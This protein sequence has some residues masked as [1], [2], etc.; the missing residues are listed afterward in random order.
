MSRLDAQLVDQHPARVRVSG[1]RLG[2]PP[3]AGQRQHQLCVEP[4]TERMF[5][6]ERPQFGDELIVAAES[7]VGLDAPLK[8]LDPHLVKPRYPRVPQRLAGHV[9]QWRALPQ[10][11]SRGRGSGGVDPRLI[12]DRR[13]RALAKALEFQHV[14]LSIGHPQQV[15]G[16]A[17]H[18]AIRAIGFEDSAEPQHVTAERRCGAGRRRAIPDRV[19]QLVDRD[20]R[21]GL[22][23]QGRQQHSKAG[24]ADA[25]ALAGVT[26]QSQRPQQDESHSATLSNTDNSKSNTGDRYLSDFGCGLGLKALA[27]NATQIKE[28]A[29]R[30]LTAPTE[31]GIRR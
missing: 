13:A 15:A 22:Q 4:L 2:L 7:Q 25:G 8:R 12:A 19:R 17:G 1:Q 6:D 21:V 27:R 10:R 29:P 24:A 28:S 14:R 18:D 23:Q 30:L 3:G 26:D 16:I 31:V 5:G 11:Q 9:G 20:R